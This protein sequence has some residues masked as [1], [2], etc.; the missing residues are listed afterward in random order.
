MKI[1]YICK[2]CDEINISTSIWKWLWT[3]HLGARKYICC[4]SCGRL[5]AMVRLDAHK[6]F[7]WSIEK[8]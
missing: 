2:Y 8:K 5:S 1:R 4:K 3:P 6:G 7:A